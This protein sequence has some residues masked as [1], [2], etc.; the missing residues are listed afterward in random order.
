MH[1]EAQRDRRDGADHAGRSSGRI[2][3]FAPVEQA[4]GYRELIADLER[5][6]AEITGYD[7]VS[8]QPNAGSQGEFAGLLAIRAYHESAGDQRRDVCL[9]PASAHGT[10]A[11]SRRDGRHAGRRG[12]LRRARQRRPRRSQREGHAARGPAR[13]ADGDLPVD[14][15]RVRRGHRRRSARSSTSTAGRC[16]STARTST[17]WSA[18]PGPASSA[19]TC[20]TST[21]T[22]RSASRT[23]VV[24][25][26]SARSVCARTSRRS[27]RTIRCCPTRARRVG[28]DQR[29][30]VGIGGHPADLVGVHPDDGCG[31]AAP[32]HR[33]RDPRRELRRPPPRAALSG[34]LH[35]RER[36]GRAR[37]HHRPATD[38]ARHRR[39][40]RRRRQAPHRL[41]LPRADDVVPGGGH[42]DDRADGVG[43]PR[44][45]RPLLRGDD[46]DPQ[47]DHRGGPASG[48]PTT[49][50]SCTRR[51]RRRRARDDWARAYHRELAAFPV[52][53]L[54][55]RKYWPP[56]GRIDRSTAT[57]T[58]SAPARRSRP[59]KTPD[60]SY[61]LC[62]TSP[63]GV[64]AACR[65]GSA[66]TMFA[67][68]SAPI[69]ISRIVS[70]GTLG[71]AAT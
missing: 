6:L 7:A 1:D 35:G 56:V 14:A 68:T 23:A 69:A 64:R 22:R 38:H 65:P 71:S 62:R 13:G 17:R 47:G 42:A 60:R 54:R 3:P 70:A 12:R 59:T 25:R 19:P 61:S 36:L 26:A 63:A 21:C 31:G 11:A 8:L 48:R 40:R 30:A 29:G 32:G 57:A 33:G 67:S 18:S 2:H 51:T 10:N 44:R 45:A 52:P 4:A 66:A 15:R 50:R 58:C 39:H 27:C 49:A 43:G 24:V 9:I 46:R 53:A 16:T 55:L 20:R 34:A 28:A 41:R 5:W 37:V